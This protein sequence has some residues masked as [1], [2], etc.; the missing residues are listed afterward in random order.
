VAARAALFSLLADDTELPALGVQQ[1]YS[2][3]A[4]DSP[5]EDCF[6][7]VRWDDTAVP[8]GR[9][10]SNLVAVWAHDRDRDYGRID[11]V[12]HRVE[13]LLAG[14]VHRTGEDGWTITQAD[15]R[16]QGPDLYDS[17]YETCTRYSNFTV[18]SR[19]EE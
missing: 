18:V 5:G 17:G 10:A 8:Y 11:A 19:K 3:N 15:P 6:L 4:V 14:T 7:I 1:V 12:L 2:A 16:G 13:D 9:V